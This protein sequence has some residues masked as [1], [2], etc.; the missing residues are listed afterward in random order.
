MSNIKVSIIIP[1]FNTEKYLHICLDSLIN[2]TLKEIEIICIDDGSTDHSLD[3]LKDYA[4]KDARIKIISKENGGQAIARNIGIDNASG[5]YI[6]FVDSD[7]YVDLEMFEKLYDHAKFND[8]DIDMC[9]VSLFEDGTTDFKDN[10]WYYALNVFNGFKKEV[11]THIDTKD[12]TCEISVTPYNKIYKNSFIKENNIK[13]AEGLIF[14]DEV[15]FFDAYLH[16][17]KVSFFKENLY[18]YR[19]DRPGS[20]VEKT[21]D[22]DYSDIVNIFKIIRKIFIET[23][24]YE[25]YKILL[26]NR[27]IHLELWRY[28]QTAKQYREYFYVI[29]K[30]DLSNLLEDNVLYNNLS[31]TIKSR[32]LK[33]LD[34]DNFNDFEEKLKSKEFSIVMACYNTDE[35]L[36]EAIL[37]VVDQ[38]FNFE[39][40]VQLILVDDGS[41]DQTRS[42]CE[43]YVELYPNNVVYLYQ[44][45]NGQASARNLGLK[46]ATG[47]YIN[48]LDSDDKLKLNT[49]SSVYDFFEKYYDEIDLV[50]VKISF[51]DRA[52]GRHPLNYKYDKSIIVNLNDYW[53]YPQLSS[54]SAFFKKELFDKFCFDTTLI[55]SEDSIMINKILLDKMAYGV[56]KD[57]EYYYRK[58]LDESS[59]IDSSIFSKEFYFDRLDNY[60]FE[61]V[62]YSIDKCGWIPKFI[63]YT[64]IYDLQWLLK[65]RDIEKILSVD[66]I[67]QIKIKIKNLLMYIDDE[68]ILK[69][70]TSSNDNIKKYILSFKYPTIVKNI[71]NQLSLFYGNQKIDVLEWHKF[72]LDILEIRNDNLYISGYC[73]SFFDID[74]L[75]IFAVKYGDN[76]KEEY[77]A[78]YVHYSKRD[79]NKI[80]SKSFENC[81][82]F[83]LIIP[84]KDYDDYTVK[85][86]IK[87]S[88]Y[89]A[90]NLDIVLESHVN[91]SKISNYSI[92]G[93]HFLEFNNNIIKI[94]KYS[95]LK[96][97]K[98]EFNVLKNI[99]QHKG[100][101]YTSVL[102]TR[103]MYMFLFLFFK[104]KRI[105]LF[106]DRQEKADDNAEHLFKYS[107]SQKDGIK[108]YFVINKDADDYKRI[109][110]YGD[111]LSFYS[112]KHRLLFLFAEKI[113][114]SHP[115]DIIFNPFMGKNVRLYSG[116]FN[117]NKYFLQHGITKDNISRW[118]HKYD[119]NIKLLVTASKMEY[120]SFLYYGYD[121]NYDED[122]VQL[123]GFPRFDN[124]INSNANQKKQ[125][126]IMPSW[127]VDLSGSS[128]EKFKQSLYFNKINSL[129][130]NGNLRDLSEKYGY[131]IIFKPHPLVNEFI[132]LFDRN[133][134]VIFDENT[135]YQKLFSESSLLI[136]DY[137]SVAFDFAYI[138][139]PVIYYQ[140]ADDYNFDETFFDYKN[141]GFGDVV[142]DELSVLNCIDNNLKNECIMDEKYIKRVDN[143]FE[144]IDNDN[145]KRVYDFLIKF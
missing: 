60:F 29:M 1:V 96:F 21:S 107:I 13:F 63:Q 71:N 73:I 54:S 123:L 118:L 91:L 55:S 87:Y 78:K 111:V 106:M 116:L 94:S 90:F 25:S 28:S 117:F 102:A 12:F 125:I 85:L 70:K 40:N 120:D 45:N 38:N 22:K 80:F 58:R 37:S 20:T 140:Y 11:F 7:D 76:D 124:L 142:T 136:T 5:E 129:I 14:E 128:E 105:W 66:E 17:K 44:E 119:K 6:G 47:K 122:V 52:E 39:G 48:F 135:T 43:K 93:K 130:N 50:S 113:I 61:L 68:V 121:Y 108:K 26:C 100:P 51:F 34:S 33:L 23:N 69:L 24:N 2:Q 143:F 86:F 131:K 98:Y 83:D 103:I 19:T 4:K 53:D 62:N 92:N 64:I 144:Y 75:R 115:D 79:K 67:E 84:L 56:I 109:S 10:V 30:E 112:I 133:D 141:D 101:Y 82:N 77:N 35:Y 139:K 127:R 36:E 3:I 18:Y 65:T 97:I 145:C 114:S 89:R 72:Y 32:V 16:A 88:N 110:K 27:F 95:Y 59:T 57:G 134:F 74:N 31:P 137:S 126:L 99:W 138:K 42:I 8:L 41:T 81:Y 104:N 15:F 46:H 49:L 132:H 9:K